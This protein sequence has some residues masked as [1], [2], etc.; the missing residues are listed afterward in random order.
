M[1]TSGK[2]LRLAFLRKTPTQQ[3]S[4]AFAWPAVLNHLAGKPFKYDKSREKDYKLP[5]DTWAMHREKTLASF[6]LRGVQPR[7]PNEPE[8]EW[9]LGRPADRQ[10]TT[11]LSHLDPSLS[12]PVVQSPYEA[13]SEGPHDSLTPIRATYTGYK[14]ESF[15]AGL[16]SSTTSVRGPSSSSSSFPRQWLPEMP[17]SQRPSAEQRTYDKAIEEGDAEGME[18]V[19]E[20]LTEALRRT[21]LRT[22]EEVRTA[23]KLLDDARKKQV[24]MFKADK[25]RRNR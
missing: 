1:S 2:E 17:P 16:P 13:A 5:L 6:T 25:R 20:S 15:V 14:T 9:H 11:P 18:G 4:Y 23:E 21:R 12:T 7:K 22:E 3:T 24:E 19:I 8:F 10:A